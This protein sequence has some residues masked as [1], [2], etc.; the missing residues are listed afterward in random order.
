MSIN[1]VDSFNSA[2]EI[3]GGFAQAVSTFTNKYET[4]RNNIPY[5]SKL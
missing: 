2:S 3:E 1:K 5:S 4:T